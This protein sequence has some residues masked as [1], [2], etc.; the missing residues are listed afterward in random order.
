MRGPR[1]GPSQSAPGIRQD[2]G[3]IRQTGGSQ[4]G[5][6]SKN[7]P[8]FQNNVMDYLN[9]LVG[10]MG[11]GTRPG[12]G[13]PDFGPHN[14][15]KPRQ[16]KWTEDPGVGV[17]PDLS[18]GGA[19]GFGGGQEFGVYA[20]GVNDDQFQKENFTG[21]GLKGVKQLEGI[22]SGI[23]GALMGGGMTPFGSMGGG[24]FSGGFGGGGDIM[25]L[26]MSLMGQMGQEDGGI[27]RGR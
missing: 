18:G 22:G 11:S 19:S 6:P 26:L 17:P 9:N 20:P 23:G 3:G 16:K 14:Q 12:V 8:R 7:L 5:S 24:G 4:F 2:V 10:Q 25:Q 21:K 15:T 13:L 27:I 1:P